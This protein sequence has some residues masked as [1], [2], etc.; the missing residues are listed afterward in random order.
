V[1]SLEETLLLT[2]SEQSPLCRLKNPRRKCLLQRI[3]LHRSHAA[4]L[5]SW[6]VAPQ[7]AQVM[8]MIPAG[9][10]LT[11]ASFRTLHIEL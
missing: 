5:N 8:G 11:V 7:M 3:L 1:L 10:K 4:P 2:H 6:N 9:N